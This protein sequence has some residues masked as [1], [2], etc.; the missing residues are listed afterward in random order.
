VLKLCS[1]CV[2]LFIVALVAAKPLWV[3]T[4]GIRSRRAK[5]QRAREAGVAPGL[6][7][8][9]AERV[10]HLPLN[11]QTLRQRNLGDDVERIVHLFRH[12]VISPGTVLEHHVHEKRLNA[13]HT[14]S[15]S[16]WSYGWYD[17]AGVLH[18]R[19]S[20]DP[21]SGR[22]NREFTPA[23]VDT[24]LVAW[25]PRSRFHVIF[26]AEGGAHVAAP[27]ALPPT[28]IRR[29]DPSVKIDLDTVEAVLRSVHEVFD[30]DHGMAVL[31]DRLIEAGDRRGEL[32]ALQLQR[33]PGEPVS[34]DETALL[35]RH[36]R[37]WLP[38]GVDP[39]FWRY[40]RG[41]LV[42]TTWCGPTDPAHSAWQTVKILS[43]VHGSLAQGPRPFDGQAPLP[44]LEEL[45]GFELADL[46]LMPASVHARVKVFRT[47]QPGSFV[48]AMLP[49]LPGL[50]RLELAYEMLDGEEARRALLAATQSAS[51]SLREVWVQQLGLPPTEVQRQLVLSGR[52]LEVCLVFGI[53]Y[54][55]SPRLPFGIWIRVT[56]TEISLYQRGT[57]HR[58][59]LSQAIEVM[60]ASGYPGATVHT[61]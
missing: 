28:R 10:Q 2:V 44:R 59:V 34:A 26:H 30:D 21:H 24:F 57:N 58:R 60:A 19:A 40:E 22:L 18:E 12:G 46:N 16:S 39:D 52:P 13:A 53:G 32:M 41:C 37:A 29:V 7:A 49:L 14:L 27:P 48:Q 43:C 33:V 51:R 20:H 17:D 31:S 8:T 3:A 50:E 35:W 11:E 54:E 4:R 6:E 47:R 55:P 25:D 15:T 36:S 5:G 42:E 38:P 23:G 61:D 56:A 1:A 9:A 45:R